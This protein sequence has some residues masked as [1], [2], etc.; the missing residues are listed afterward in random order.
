MMNLINTPSI[1]NLKM[2][3]MKLY[4]LLVC[5]FGVYRL[6][7]YFFTNMETSPLPMKS[8]K[9]FTYA[10][11]SWQLSCEGSLTCH[12]YCDTGHPFKMAISEEP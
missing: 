3:C 2:L 9:F 10:G 4:Y 6:T 1:T 7:R 12:T 11:H 8:C 5:L